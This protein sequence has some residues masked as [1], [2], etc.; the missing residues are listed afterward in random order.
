MEIQIAIDA[1]PI[2]IVGFFTTIIVLIL[3]I[4]LRPRYHVVV[5]QDEIIR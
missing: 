4:G 1:S 2:I 3:V 5:K